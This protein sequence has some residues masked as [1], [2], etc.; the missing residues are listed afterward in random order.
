MHFKC[1]LNKDCSAQRACLETMV[2]LDDL[3]LKACRGY[4]GPLENSVLR[5]LTEMTVCQD[6]PETLDW[7]DFQVK[8]E[9]LKHYLYLI[10][11]HEIHLGGKGDA[12]LPGPTGAP[13]VNGNPGSPG[14]PGEKGLSGKDGQPGLP[15]F[16]GLLG[17]Q[18][19]N[20]FSHT[21]SI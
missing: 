20:V 3:V 11:E 13:G 10:C 16:S 14:M 12:G 7:M 18:T 9:I 8:R 19:T 21:Y 15:G 1:K 17:K 5:V 4:R 6:H 2:G